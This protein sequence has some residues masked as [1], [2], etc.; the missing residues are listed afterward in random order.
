MTTH[1]TKEAVRLEGYQAI[2]RPS[3]KYNNHTLSAIVDE[4]IIDDLEAERV[5]AL[6]WA[7]SK[8]KNPKKVMEKFA[9]WEEVDG[10][11]QIKFSWK[12]DQS[13]PIV[14][15]E[16]VPITDEIPLYSGSLVKLAFRQKPYVLPDAIGTSLKLQAIQVIQAAGTAAIDRGD[17]SDADVAE[18]FGKSNG[19]KVGDPN[20]VATEESNDF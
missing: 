15:S 11:Y 12:P 8:A 10:G 4:S 6:D 17:L 2:F 1:V 20:V 9:P 14:D 5:G 19:F 18:L 7:R 16:G 13:I 3:E